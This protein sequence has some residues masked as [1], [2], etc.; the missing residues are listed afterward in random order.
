MVTKQRKCAC[1]YNAVDEVRHLHSESE[2]GR[3][4]F[5]ERGERKWREGRGIYSS[6]RKV[7]VE[8]AGSKRKKE[9]KG[10]NI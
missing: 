5:E 4:G 10:R 7:G 8:E 6:G 1:I 2:R 3:E 9:E